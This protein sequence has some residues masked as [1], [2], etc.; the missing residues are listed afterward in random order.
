MV[1]SRTF[2]ESGERNLLLGGEIAI[3]VPVRLLHGQ[4]DPDVPWR[5]ALALAEKLR[6]ADVQTILVKDGDHRLS[7]DRD[8]ALLIA[9]V[10]ALLESL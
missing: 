4:R 5:N 8:I 6:S 10:A 7:R 1:T 2:W 9:T 3:H